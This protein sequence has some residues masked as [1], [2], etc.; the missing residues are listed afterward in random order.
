MALIESF[1][2]KESSK[3]SHIH[4]YFG[5]SGAH[6][7]PFGTEKVTGFESRESMRKSLIRLCKYLSRQPTMYP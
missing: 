7:R 4:A 6:M 5:G 2:E 3:R 1:I